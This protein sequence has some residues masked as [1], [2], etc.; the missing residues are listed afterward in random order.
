MAQA[1]GLPGY[2]A[3]HDGDLVAVAV[4][5]LEPG[6]VEGGYLRGPE[7]V[8]IELLEPV[9]LGHKLALTDIAE[10]QDVIEYGQR[11]GIATADIPKGG[12][13]HVH[14]VRSARWQNSVA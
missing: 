11:V 1:T 3:H 9:P 6:P 12:Y 10:G 4:R 7:N 13:V 8:T 14:N 2:L 5:D